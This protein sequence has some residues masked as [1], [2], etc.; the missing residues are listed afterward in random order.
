MSMCARP[1]RMP[2]K[3]SVRERIAGGYIMN[4]ANIF[5]P[6]DTGRRLTARG[7]KDLFTAWG[8]AWALTLMNTQGL[9]VRQK[10]WKRET[11]SPWSRDYI[12]R[13]WEAFAL[14]IWCSSR[15]RAV[16]I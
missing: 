7:Q 3:K 4:C 15:P 8:T 16:K 12:I 14:K 11:S 5:Q 13:A 9:G 1:R 2:L 6:R 10:Y